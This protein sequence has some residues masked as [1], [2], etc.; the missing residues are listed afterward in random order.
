MDAIF[1]TDTY[2]LRVIT[3]HLVGGYWKV[4]CYIERRF[5]STLRLIMGF[6]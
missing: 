1:T 5:R 2:L 6:T 4:N 3:Y